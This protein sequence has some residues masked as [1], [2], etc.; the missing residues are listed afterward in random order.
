MY[1]F[2]PIFVAILTNLPLCGG[3]KMDC[4][5]L[6]PDKLNFSLFFNEK[7]NNRVSSFLSVRFMM[8]YD[9]VV[10]N[11]LM[12]LAKMMLGSCICD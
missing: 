11:M 7:K 5:E 10:A 9:L 12:F 1:Y 4:V 8:I 2:E 3:N 6:L